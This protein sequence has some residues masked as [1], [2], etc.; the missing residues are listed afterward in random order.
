[1]KVLLI[2]DER[3]LVSTL[4]ERLALRGIEADWAA[5]GQ[6]GLAKAEQA[7]YQWAVIDLKMP[8]LDGRRVI[9][10]I[11]E[12]HPDMKI[13]LVSGHSA[14]AELDACRL[15]G[16]DCFLVKPFDLEELVARLRGE[17]KGR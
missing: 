7:H 15:A 5:D 16:A 4:C 14:A 9:E 17:E 10:L 2:D 13:I 1:M 3:E 11:K 12:K 8:G 6:E